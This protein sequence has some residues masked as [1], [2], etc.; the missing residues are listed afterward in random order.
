MKTLKSAV[1]WGYLGTV[2]KI[3]SQFLTQILLLRVVGPHAYGT[4]AAAFFILTLAMIAAEMGLTAAVIHE[5][6][7]NDEEKARILTLSM[8]AAVIAGLLM[9]A[10]SPV[11]ATFFHDN[12][13]GAVIIVLAIVPFFQAPGNIAIGLLRKNLDIKSVQISQLIGYLFGFSFVG[14][15]FAVADF[16]AYSLAFAW[17]AQSIV[18]SFIAMRKS[19]LKL[20]LS[21]QLKSCKEQMNYGIKVFATNISNWVVEN[22][23]A[24]VIGRIFG[25]YS[26]GLYSATY[27]FV[28]NPTNH[29]I[30]TVQTIAL[31]IARNKV[32]DVEWTKRF[33]LILIMFI[34]LIATLVFASLSALSDYAVPVIFGSKWSGATDVLAPLSIAMIF[35]SIMAAVGPVLWGRNRVGAELRVQVII[36]ILMAVTLLC[37]AKTS[38]VYAAWAITIVL[39]LRCVGILM[40]LRKEMNISFIEFLGAIRGSLIMGGVIYVLTPHLAALCPDNITKVVIVPIALLCINLLIWLV[41]PSIYIEKRILPSKINIP[42]WI[43]VFV[44]QRIRLLA[45]EDK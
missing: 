38:I 23:G 6:E 30:N 36:A 5:K 26:L 18:T 34:S 11:V 33:V 13:V 3:V 1:L 43:P 24:F 7:M 39:A 27:Q 29:L 8:V 21:L 12:G 25:A 15:L 42:K 14:V 9:T 44:A 22:L 35:H 37:L 17:I 19:G 41:K 10:I 32:D 28:K 2:V 31:P 4:Y 16:G 40:A 45:A 20:K